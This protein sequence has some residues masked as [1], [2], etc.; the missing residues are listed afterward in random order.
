MYLEKKEPSKKEKNPLAMGYNRPMYGAK[1]SGMERTVLRHL[2]E[3]KADLERFRK[4]IGDGIS[5]SEMFDGQSPATKSTAVDY[6]YDTFMDNRSKIKSPENDIYHWMKKPFDEFVDFV[7]GIVRDSDERKALAKK[8]SEGAKLVYEDD[9]WYV[10]HITNYEASCKYGKGTKWC[11]SGSK[12]WNNGERG[13]DYFDQYSEDGIV[14]YF[15]IDRNNGRKYALCLYP[16]GSNW[17]IYNDADLRVPY[18]PNAPFV[19][20]IADIRNVDDAFYSK[21]SP[22]NELVT[23]MA[24]GNISPRTF[25]QLVELAKEP[26]FN[27]L[28]EDE[29]FGIYKGKD[30]RDEIDYCIPDGFLEW[31]ATREGQM[32]VAEYER[33]TGEKFPEDPDGDG[34]WSGDWPIIENY[35]K[36]PNWFRGKKAVLDSMGDDTTLLLF[37][38]SMSGETIPYFARDMKDAL[39]EASRHNGEILDALANVVITKVGR[40]EFDPEGVAKEFGITDPTF[41][42]GLRNQSGHPVGATPETEAIHETNEELQDIQNDS[43]DEWYTEN[44]YDVVDSIKHGNK[45][46]RILPLGTTGAYAIQDAE[47]DRTHNDL[48]DDIHRDGFITDDEWYDIDIWMGMVFFPNGYDKKGLRYRTSLGDDGY[49]ICLVY[50]FGTMYFRQ[51]EATLDPLVNAL[52]KPEHSIALQSYDDRKD[53]FGG[54]RGVTLEVD[55]RKKYVD[56]DRLGLAFKNIDIVNDVPESELFKESLHEDEGS[57]VLYHGTGDRFDRF[58]NKVNWLASDESYARYYALSLRDEGLIYECSYVL[59]NLFDMGKTGYRVYRPY[60]VSEPYK[61]S[62]E[63][64]ETVSELGLSDSEL[65]E[66]LHAVAKEFDE[67]GNGYGMKA[68][69]VAR[70]EAFREVLMDR[71]F[72]GVKAIEYDVPEKKYCTTYGVYDPSSIRIDSVRE[73]SVHGERGESLGE[74]LPSRLYDVT[75]EYA[76]WTEEGT[77]YRYGDSMGSKWDPGYARSYRVRMSPKQFLDLTTEGGADS[78]RLGQEIGTGA[79]SEFD[80]EKFS[81]ERVQPLFL[82]VSFKDEKDPELAQVTGH[83]G[84]H[85]MFALMKKGVK[86]VDVELMCDQ[87]FTTFNRYKPFKL[88]R[89]TLIGQYDESVRVTLNRPLPMSYETQ[90]TSLDESAKTDFVARFGQDMLQKFDKA[91]DRFRNKGKSVD[92]GQYLSLTPEEMQAEI[93]SVYD[94]VKDA[95]RLRNIRGDTEIRGD[96]EYLGEKNGYKVYEAKDHLS[97]M[98][99]GVGSG[100]CISGRYGHANQPIFTPSEK[101]AKRH[102]DD[103]ASKG[104]RFFMFV[105]D[106]Q[107]KYCLALYPKVLHP[108]TRATEYVQ[109]DGKWIESTIL[110]KST[111]FELYDQQ[112]RNGYDPYANKDGL[113]RNK[114]PFDL[115]HEELVLDIERP[116]ETKFLGYVELN[117]GE[118]LGLR[119]YN[120]NPLVIGCYLYEPPKCRFND[121][122]STLSEWYD[123]E[124]PDAIKKIFPKEALWNLCVENIFDF[125]KENKR[126]RFKGA[127]AKS[128]SPYRFRLSA[129]E[130]RLDR[131]YLKWCWLDNLYSNDYNGRNIAWLVTNGGDLDYYY[132][133]F[134]G[135]CVCPAFF[136]DATLED[137]ESRLAEAGI[138]L[139]SLHESLR[140]SAEPTKTGKAYKLFKVKDG[141]LYPPMVPNPEGKDTPVGVW[142]DAQEGEFAGLSKTGRPQVKS[143]GSGKLAYRP[144]WHLGDLPYAPQF[145]SRS[146]PGYMSAPNFVWAECSYAMDMDY[147]DEADAQGYVRTSMDQ[148]GNVISTTSDKYQHSLAGLKRIP[149]NGYYRYRTNPNPDTIPWVIT[150]KMRVDRILSDEEVERI[151]SENGV[152]YLKRPGGEKSLADLGLSESLHEASNGMPTADE[153]TEALRDA[154]L[155]THDYVSKP[156][157]ILPNGEFVDSTGKAVQDKKNGTVT[158]HYMVCK[159][160]GVYGSSSAPQEL[161]SDYGWVRYNPFRRYSY[162]EIPNTLPTNEQLE[163]IKVAFE[164][165]FFSNGE[166][167][168]YLPDQQGNYD[169][170]QIDENKNVIGIIKRHFSSLNRSYSING[171]EL[172]SNLKSLIENGVLA[173]EDVVKWLAPDI[174]STTDIRISDGS[175]ITIDGLSKHDYDRLKEWTEDSNLEKCTLLYRWLEDFAETTLNHIKKNSQSAESNQSESL[176]ESD[177]TETIVKALEDAYKPTMDAEPNRGPCYLLRDGRFLYLDNVHVRGGTDAYYNDKSIHGDEREYLVVKCGFDKRDVANALNEYFRGALDNNDGAYRSWE[178]VVRIDSSVPPTP[179]QY[180]QLKKWLDN[181]IYEPN[182]RDF[183]NVVAHSPN[184]SSKFGYGGRFITDSYQKYALDGID[185]DYIIDRIRKYYSFGRLI[186]GHTLHEEPVFDKDQTPFGDVAETDS[187]GRPLSTGQISYFKNSKVRDSEGRLLVCY[188]GTHASFTKFENGDVGFHFGTIEQANARVDDTHYGNDDFDK[189]G[190]NIKPCYLNIRNPWILKYDP[191]TFHPLFIMLELINPSVAS[192]LYPTNGE[193]LIS[194]EDRK[195]LAKKYQLPCEFNI[196]EGS[197]FPKVAPEDFEAFFVDY[198]DDMANSVEVWYEFYEKSLRDDTVSL[199]EKAGYDGI[200]YPNAWENY[201]GEMHL[202]GYDSNEPSWVIFHSNQAKSIFNTHPTSSDDITETIVEKIVRKGS[203]WQVQ[204]ENGRNMGTYDTKEEAEKRLRQIEYFKHRDESFDGRVYRGTGRGVGGDMYGVGKYYASSR[205]DASRYGDVSEHDIALENP[206]VLDGDRFTLDSF[207]VGNFHDEVEKEVPGYYGEFHPFG[208]LPKGISTKIAKD[209]GHDGVIVEFGNGSK[210]YVVFDRINESLPITESKQ[211][212]ANFANWLRRHFAED[213]RLLLP[214]WKKYGISDVNDVIDAFE[215]YRKDNKGQHTDYYYW[216][217]GDYPWRFYEFI[218]RYLEG[219]SASSEDRKRESEGAERIFEDDKWYVYK[220]TTPEAAKRYGRGTKWC[221]TSEYDFDDYLEDGNVAYFLFVIPKDVKKYMKYAVGFTVD[222]QPVT[223]LFDQEDCIVNGIPYLPKV[224][225]LINHFLNANEMLFDDYFYIDDG[226]GQTIANLKD[227]LN[228]NFPWVDYLWFLLDDDD[229]IKRKLSEYTRIPVD[230]IKES[231]AYGVNEES[232]RSKKNINKRIKLYFQNKYG[233]KLNKGATVHH[234]VTSNNK[235]FSDFYASENDDTFASAMD[236]VAIIDAGDD[237][238]NTHFNDAVHRLFDLVNGHFGKRDL[239]TLFD[240]I[241]NATVYYMDNGELR[242]EPFSAVVGKDKFAF[243]K[244]SFNRLES[245][246]RQEE[247]LHESKHELTEFDFWDF[248]SPYQVKNF[249]LGRTE[250][251]RVFVDQ[252][253][254]VYLAC[255]SFEAT[256]SDMCHHYLTDGHADPEYLRKKRGENYRSDF[257]FPLMDDYD[258]EQVCLIF[259]PNGSEGDFDEIG[260]AI[261]DDYTTCYEYPDFKIYAREYANRFKNFDLYKAFGEPENIRDISTLRDESLR[262]PVDVDE[263]KPYNVAKDMG[264]DMRNED[265]EKHDTLNPVLF[266]GDALKPEVSDAIRNVV[267]AFVEELGRDGIDIS[268]K[269]VVLVGSNVSYNYTKDSDVDVHVIVDSSKLDCPKEIVDRLYGAYRSIFNGNYD[270]TI[271]GIP[272]EVYV[273]LDD[274]GSAKSN[275]VYSLDNGWIKEPTQEEIPDLDREAFDAL[276]GEWEG[277]YLDLIDSDG[278]DSETVKGFIEEIYDLRKEGIANEGEYSLQN[279][280]FKEFRNLGYL[281]RLKELRKALKGNELSLEAMNESMRSKNAGRLFELLGVSVGVDYVIISTDTEKRKKGKMYQQAKDSLGNHDATGVWRRKKNPNTYI[282][283][284]SSD[285]AKTLAKNLCQLEFIMIRFDSE[286]S[287]VADVWRT[288]N[289]RTYSDYEKVDGWSSSS[290]VFGRKATSQTGYTI[291]RGTPFSLGVYGGEEKPPFNELTE[292]LKGNTAYMLR[293]DGTLFDCSPIHPYVLLY[294]NESIETNL[295]ALEDHPGF[296]DWFIEH[297]NDQKVREAMERIKGGDRSEETLREANRLANDEFC[298]VR[299]SNIKYTYGGDNGEIYFRIASTDGFN[300]YDAIWN[301]VMEGRDW[302]GYVTV[303]KDKPIVGNR[304]EYYS[305][306]G[307]E[308]RHVPVDTFLTLKGEPVLEKSGDC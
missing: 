298:R 260:D 86:S 20:E 204:S 281:D 71:G 245:L 198:E 213:G 72:D 261:Y 97:A 257:P 199:I 133:N 7:T 267:D 206:I 74:A 67:A 246:V 291:V 308:L 274:L 52:G 115:I 258:P 26:D 251:M 249:L 95:Q 185:A 234:L 277:R 40:R 285:D 98:D 303:I 139:E 250:P 124:L 266:D 54:I 216:M 170:K 24:E 60:P 143:S 212:S 306:G 180:Q 53:P 288:T 222:D 237:T 214:S 262:K 271:K 50:P 93:E 175:Y 287:F 183:I 85:R 147:Q 197:D 29:M 44:L 116:T 138:K 165:M 38:D 295:K 33:L 34:Y 302:I 205:E 63:F 141:K 117:S 16:N 235:A 123:S 8:E 269:D 32:G 157:Y 47:G 140:E 70:S 154:G 104:V 100:W 56:F 106:G 299:T 12:W 39:L 305:V 112:D 114:L 121:I 142:L 276:F 61:I 91:R 101:D 107:G 161:V 18:I 102:F 227:S 62:Q 164:E 201:A 92:Y 223:D 81:S 42:D 255:V 233:I 151:C 13:R 94:E 193:I 59:G 195:A 45:P 200:M 241:S 202:G 128:E 49:G 248:E 113:A 132:V 215:Q 301:V 290:V 229:T 174:E 135:C 17:E 243:D 231:T 145:E 188:H 80:P 125:N 131:S 240:L 136:L 218:E 232:S 178:T 73:V 105:K 224:P 293:R 252:E 120:E 69:T 263:S 278:L 9:D 88:D 31:E 244:D 66:L 289:R 25:N 272:V 110:V 169:V 256:H 264:T 2:R 187:I 77:A 226:Q 129:F 191:R 273:E 152:P 304:Q 189:D 126:K 27:L 156:S 210:Y 219:R 192:Y 265:I 15:F 236:K 159:L 137:V 3:S 111:N 307:D 172:P 228:I 150:G 253:G 48:A 177:V 144:G 160:L 22:Y 30:A 148:D 28:Y 208:E 190:S 286:T 19:K 118:Y 51:W 297:S 294:P 36:L 221:I 108:N 119:V 78:L 209:L 130:N 68:S 254:P 41:V 127:I 43:C 182:G 122:K 10:Y 90:G 300:W 82:Q 171:L 155:L 163:S 21:S 84:R 103:Y 46:L 76:H 162:I 134:K 181:I 225:Q 211:D 4:W 283:P 242:H 203:K 83:E 280:V 79:L 279:L 89:I 11:I 96:Y 64:E 23:A 1:F 87:Y 259:V 268:V 207:V 146:N 99:L 167:N 58:G 282:R 149:T 292:A 296:I 284:M 270:I 35:E 194:D 5:V 75:D 57:L 247:S 238:A 179:V 166:V 109:R 230:A 153:A 6:L 220:I 275:G 239:A 217:K 184:P 173:E 176:H 186:E 14:L 65:R 196:G 37:G 168:L 158:C 55:G